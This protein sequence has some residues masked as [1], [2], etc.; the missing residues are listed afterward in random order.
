MATGQELIVSL[1]VSARPYKENFGMVEASV[2][3]TAASMAP[4]ISFIPLLFLV[5]ESVLASLF[6]DP[7]QLRSTTYDYVIVGGELCFS[8]FFSNIR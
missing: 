6:T 8:S 1:R 7:S 2:L 4:T 5:A 3:A